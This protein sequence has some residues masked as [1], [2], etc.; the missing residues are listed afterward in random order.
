MSAKKSKLLEDLSNQPEVAVCG[1]KVIL[2]SVTPD[3]ADALRKIFEQK[4]QNTNNSVPWQK[5]K[6]T[7]SWL[8]DVLA[9]NGHPISRQGLTNH[10][11][12]RCACYGS[13]G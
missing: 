8:M 6:I 4:L 10:I 12:K 11:W 1:V 2:D 13:V 3:E 5:N 7:Y 9:K